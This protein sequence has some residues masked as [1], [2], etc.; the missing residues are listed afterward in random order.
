MAVATTNPSFTDKLR[1]KNKINPEM[2]ERFTDKL[3]KKN[4]I[5]PEMDERFI[6][7]A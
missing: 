5:N 2:D 1:K 4:K 6:Q 3:R 7:V